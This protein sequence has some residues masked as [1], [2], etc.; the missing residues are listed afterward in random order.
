L[1]LR[2][3]DANLYA[4][5]FIAA[6]ESTASTNGSKT[7][8]I[9][10]PPIQRIT[11]VLQ[12]T[13]R[14]PTTGVLAG[15]SYLV[16]NASS[17]GSALNIVQASNGTQ[18]IS[19][20]NTHTAELTALVNTPTTPA[21]WRLALWP[22]AGVVVANANAPL[23]QFSVSTSAAI[24]VGT[25]ELGHASDTTLSR[26]AAGTL[27]VEGVVVPT[28]S[29]TNT[30]SNKTLA[31]PV[32]QG[33]NEATTTAT[34]SNAYTFVIT[35]STQFIITL[36]ANT[37]CTFTMPAVSTTNSFTVQLR[38]PAA[39]GNGAASFL[40][41]RWPTNGVPTITTTAGRMDIINFLSDG[42][43]WYGSYVQGYIY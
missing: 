4:D 34:V 6:V 14:L 19:F 41:V 8:T 28:I 31:A 30:L 15:Q 43:N 35:A 36:T 20:L 26:S 40:N 13:V 9:A 22:N 29:S 42:T 33:F 3:A 17:S 37:T 24:G 32:I 25:I 39:T 38:Q 12:M 11:G 7:L 27:A 2:D 1:A 23:S 16:I 18:I 21:H 5:N 10:S